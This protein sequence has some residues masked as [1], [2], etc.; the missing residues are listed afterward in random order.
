MYFPVEF[1]N[2]A[3]SIL[4]SSTEIPICIQ[5]KLYVKQE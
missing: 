2:A 4:S 3:S 5:K 1:A